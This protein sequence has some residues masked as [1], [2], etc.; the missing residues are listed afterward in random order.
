[1]V[2]HCC[3]CRDCQ[4]Q[5]G[6]AFAINALVE[7]E[8][9]RCESGDIEVTSMP[10]PSGRGHEIHRCASCLTAVWS[11]Y[12]RRPFLRFLRV[13]TLDDAHSIVPD[14]HIFTR[15]KVPWVALPNGVPVFDVYYD[16]E[17]LWRPE[18]LARRAAM[19]VEAGASQ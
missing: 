14:V 8:Y 19:L 12:G 4:I 3:H 13:S 17:R 9:I 16:V 15:S 2:V 1:M 10:S 5:T 7:T 6:G 11:D 18:S